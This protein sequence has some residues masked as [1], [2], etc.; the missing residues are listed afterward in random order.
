V[1]NRK[2]DEILKKIL[3]ISGSLGLGHVARDLAIAKELRYQFSDTEIHWIAAEPALSVL[4]AAGEKTVPEVNIYNNDNDY[5]EAA[6]KGPELSQQIYA[7]KVLGKWFQNA[8]IL[9]K[10]LKKNDFDL[11][12]GDE[13]YEIIVAMV[14]NLLKLD[15]PFVVIY[16]FLG[17]DTNSKNPFEYLIGFFFNRIWSLDYKLFKDGKNLA[18]FVGELEDI[19]DKRFGSALPNRRAY[20]KKY[21][22]FL[23]YILSFNP[24][25]YND[26]KEIRQKLGYEDR[27]LIICT[28]GGTSVGKELLELCAKAYPVIK[29]K[30]PNLHMVLVCGPRLAAESLNISKDIDLREYVPNLY[31]HLAASDIAVTQGGGT[32]TLELTALNKPFIYFPLVGHT[33]QENVISPRLDRYSAGIRMSYLKID[34]KM[35]AEAIIENINTEVNYKEVPL[36]GAKNAVKLLSRFF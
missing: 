1:I 22:N 16:D 10:I 8:N 7:F 26:K 31:E 9:K 13:T 27:P 5:A 14:L 36:N 18:L 24:G 21:Y 20:A 6:A 25:Q 3:F 28:I 12:I 32:T 29:E 30:I 35:L 2:K 17:L 15:T 34:E 4:V 19:P 11:I 33:E 23:G